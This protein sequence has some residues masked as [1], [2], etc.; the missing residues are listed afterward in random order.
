MTHTTAHTAPSHD[1]A[2]APAEG[3]LP[4]PLSAFVGRQRELAEAERLLAEARL[5]TLVGAGGSGK[6]RLALEV[7]RRAA[8]GFAGAVAWVDL[9][10]LEDAALVPR[11]V[12]GTLGLREEGTGTPLDALVGFLRRRA[13]L[14]VLDNCEHVVDAVAPV[15]ETLLRECPHLTILATSREPLAIPGERAW[16]VPP[17][18]LPASAATVAEASA[19]EAI[20]L[21]V[22]RARDVLPSF[23]LTAANVAAVVEICRR[24]DGIPLA[25]ELA[26]A[27]VR[28]LAPE[29]IARRLDDAFGLLTTG[30]RTALPRHRTLRATMEWS[31]RLLS[32]PEQVLLRRLGVFAGGFTLEAVESVC[33]GGEVGPDAA[34]D[35]LA[36][37]VDRSLVVVRERETSARYHLLETVRQYALEALAASGE[38]AALREAHARHVLAQVQATAPRLT[39]PERPAAMARL[40]PDVDNVRQALRWSRDAA[41]VLH[42]QLAGSLGWYW[43]FSRHWSEGRASMEAALALPGAA[44]PGADR[45]ALLFAIG[46]LATL[47]GDAGRAVAA[48]RESVALAETRGDER[49]VAWATVYLGHA[50]AVSGGAEG[51]ALSERAGAWFAGSGEAFGRFVIELILGAHAIAQGDARSARAHAESALRLA[52][53]SGLDHDIAVA[54]QSLAY[55]LFDLDEPSAAIRATQAAIERLRRDPVLLF[56]ARAL[57]LVAMGA[58]GQA[59]WPE[60]VELF[61]AAASLRETIGARFYRID[62]DRY[63]PRLAAARAALGD[64]AFEAA[65]AEGSALPYEAALDRALAFPAGGMPPSPPVE[66]PPE[67]AAAAAALHVRALGPLEIHVDGVRLGADAWRSARPRELFLYLLLHPDGRT[68][69]QI[70]LVF[71]PDASAA[72]LRNNFHVTLH[73]VRKALG[74]PHAVVI[75]RGRYRLDPALGTWCDAL[76]F[77]RELH[78]ALRRARAGEDVR[79][80][81]VAALSAY[82][83]DLFEGLDVGDWHLEA[84]DHLRR[85][86]EEGCWVLAQ[87]HRAAGDVAAA[88][89]VLERLV[90]LDDLREDAHRALMEAWGACGQRGRALAHHR[91]FVERLRRE[92]DAEPESATTA[93]YARLLQAGGA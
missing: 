34:L 2:P 19:T 79:A 6:T 12:A 77:P 39:T 31:V 20:E 50:I 25:L 10:A 71:W 3:R 8:A 65:W 61:A 72:Q 53:A 85:L 22:A 70:G 32:P 42:V 58:G 37:L 21:F 11:E 27:R 28:A 38:E 48:L 74:R 41:P 7:A 92:L 60:A 76:V 26:A 54:E 91:E 93:V 89:P 59:R 52:T 82:R 30:G 87:A 63:L 14:V 9:A 24:L 88:I 5:L 90:R 29:Q 73:H 23:A 40:E 47:Q 84:H 64:A 43:Y 81:L 15:A 45:G 46:M 17:L 57:E 86:A 69:E 75:E 68:R 44:D 33:A 13:S 49:A 4:Q 78:E 55:A 18:A 16:L 51:R 80:P 62:D 66:R 35:L 83:G 36:Q 56:F 1:R 67:R